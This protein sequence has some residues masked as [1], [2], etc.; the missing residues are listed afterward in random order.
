MRDGQTANATGDCSSGTFNTPILTEKSGTVRFMDIKEKV[1]VRDEVDE[2]TGLRL[3]VI[4]DDREKVLHPTS[5]SSAR[6]AAGWR[7]IRPDR[8]A[9]PRAGRAG[10]HGRRGAGQDPARDLKTRDITGGLPRVRGSCSRRASRRDA[11]TVAESTS[12]WSSAAWPSAEKAPGRRGLARFRRTR[13]YLIPQG[14]HLHVQ[15]DTVG[16]ATG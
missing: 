7:A 13:E 14:K 2:N 8:R 11:A 4:I 16:R 12:A 9:A 10:G 5:T 6:A 3:M 15:E 1:T